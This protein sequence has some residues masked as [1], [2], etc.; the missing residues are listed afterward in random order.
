VYREQGTVG[1]K[2]ANKQGNTIQ[3]YIITE[4]GIPILRIQMTQSINDDMR[5][6]MLRQVMATKHTLWIHADMTQ[7]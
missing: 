6:S 2:P 1:Q 3:Q 5:R 4:V 7:I